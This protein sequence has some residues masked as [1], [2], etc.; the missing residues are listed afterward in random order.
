SVD[1]LVVA[2]DR[3]RRRREQRLRKSL[4]FPHA[5]PELVPTD[6]TG[7]AVILPARAGQVAA[8][9]ALD[10]EHLESATLGRPAVF[11][12]RSEV[13]RTDVRRPGEPPRREACQDAALVGYLGRKDDV[14]RRDP[15]AGHEEQTL[16]VERE[17]LADLSA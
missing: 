16:V 12:E 7:R 17:E 8:N 11:A 10:R 6:R 3:L 4:G 5:S 2:G 13:I 1:V 14:E 9:D 15:V